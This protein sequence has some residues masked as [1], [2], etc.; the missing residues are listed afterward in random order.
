MKSNSID[1]IR[2]LLKNSR[3]VKQAPLWMGVIIVV[4]IIGGGTNAALLAML[5]YLLGHIAPASNKLIII[6]VALCIALPLTRFG[7]EAML[8][9]L[10]SK[11]MLV[12]RMR[13]SR[14]ILSAPLRRLEEFGPHRLLATLAEDVPIIGNSLVTIPVII[15]HISIVIGCLI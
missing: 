15:M 12:L 11:A 3:A 4:G 8:L 9:N 1:L 2:F 10:S 14:Q 7:S 6:Y 13:L 5:G